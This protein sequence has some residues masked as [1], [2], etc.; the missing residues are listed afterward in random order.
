MGNTYSLH[1]VV[2]G[3]SWVSDNGTILLFFFIILFYFFFYYSY[4]HTRL[5]NYL[6]EKS[7]S[8]GECARTQSQL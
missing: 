8:C 5:G 3:K 4:V 6:I 2:K 7:H 1:F